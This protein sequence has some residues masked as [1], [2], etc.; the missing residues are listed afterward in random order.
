MNRRSFLGQTAFG[1]AGFF[2][3]SQRPRTRHLIFIV[4]G[5]ARKKDYYEDE[6]L[7]PNIRRL[8]DEGFVFEED[9]CER[10]ASHDLAFAELLSGRES[11][12]DNRPYPNIFDYLNCKKWICPSLGLVPEIMDA[13]KPPILVCRETA[14]DAGHDS[15]EKYLRAV[16]ATDAGVGRLF[17]WIK[18]HPDFSQ[19][20]AIVIRPEFGRD[21][22]VNG[23]GQLHHSEGFYYTHR[24]A[25]IFWGP[26][27]KQGVDRKTII[28]RL[29]MTPTLAAL[30]GVKAVH[31][32]G[33]VM[34]GLLKFSI[35]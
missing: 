2:L 22:E 10:I 3:S 28:R 23:Q 21:D 33:R 26:D 17:D 7:S 14:H 13:H 24:V 6:F 5:A 34:P 31:A 16:K 35:A 30:F 8:A 4:N 27:F 11:I 12:P 9:H 29:D 15:Y 1:A 19:N 18:A 32:H 20:T 25:S